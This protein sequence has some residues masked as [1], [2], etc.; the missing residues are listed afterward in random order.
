MQ[1]SN[2]VDVLA[3]DL[4]L[5]IARLRQYGVLDRDTV[6]AIDRLERGDRSAEPSEV[7]PYVVPT[8]KDGLLLLLDDKQ[9]EFKLAP[10]DGAELAVQILRAYCATFGFIVEIGIPPEHPGHVP[11][12][13]QAAIDA[14]TLRVAP[15]SA[16]MATLKTKEHR[17]PGYHVFE[18]IRERVLRD[19]RRALGF[20]GVG[21]DRIEG[22]KAY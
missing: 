9:H 12:P 8:L 7:R 17:K 18:T 15:G 19:A 5:L 2:T 6:E 21:A 11:N 14:P 4:E 22:P 1:G 16:V 10:R 13:I 3:R 20:A